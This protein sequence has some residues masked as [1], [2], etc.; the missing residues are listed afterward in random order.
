MVGK[1]YLG[2]CGYQSCVNCSV[3]TYYNAECHASESCIMSNI[4]SQVRDVD[5]SGYLSCA[6]SE[7]LK[8]YD[9]VFCASK[10]T[11]LNVGSIS[12]NDYVTCNG[13]NSCSNSI[14]KDAS[15]IES[16]GTFSL[17]NATIY[18]GNHSNTMKIYL[19]GYY[20]GYNLT[21]YCQ[22]SDTCE[23]YCYGNNCYDTQFYCNDSISNCY[24]SC[25]D[26]NN[27]IC[28]IFNTGTAATNDTYTNVI[29]NDFYKLYAINYTAGEAILKELL[30][31]LTH[32]NSSTNELD[33]NDYQQCEYYNI[34]LHQKRIL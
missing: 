10:Y 32:D 7:Q 12:A 5:C 26:T 18:S 23:L 6:F 33:C 2:C 4:T 17:Y 11:C 31:A 9:D 1:D 15:Y 22:E 28:P 25:N 21:V 30:L 8:G 29:N 3:N 13:D 16:R 19:D 24:V 27:D 34:N 20:T 14:I